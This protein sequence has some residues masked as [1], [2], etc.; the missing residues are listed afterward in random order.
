M[1]VTGHDGDALGVDGAQVGVLEEADDVGQSQAS[2]AAEGGGWRRSGS[3]AVQVLGDFARR[4]AA[5]QGKL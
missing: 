5:P 3:G 4:E 1:D 2:A